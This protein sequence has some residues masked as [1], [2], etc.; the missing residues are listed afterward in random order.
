MIPYS[1]EEGTASVVGQDQ[2]RLE[3]HG[4]IPDAGP[5]AR[6][7]HQDCAEEKATK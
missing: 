3:P 5:A 2:G 4:E 6:A 1:G 7:P